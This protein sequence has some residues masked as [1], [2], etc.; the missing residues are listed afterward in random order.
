MHPV[1]REGITGGL[2]LGDLVFVMGE[3]E[4]HPTTVDIE[5][6]TEIARCHR[7]AL[8]MPTG[9]TRTPGRGPLRLAGL[10]GLRG[11]P[12]S[13]VTRVALDRGIGV[14]RGLH[15][16]EALPAQGA[17]LREGA[18]VEV[19]IATGGVGMTVVDEALHELDHFGHVTGG[20]RLVGRWQAAEHVVGP[21]EGTLIAHSHLP[22]GHALLG[23]PREDLV[24]DVGDVAHE[25]DVVARG[26]QPPPQ[27]VEG[28][29]GS[30]VAHMGWRLH[31]GPAEVDRHPAR[32]QGHEVAHRA[33]RGVVEAQGH[34]HRLVGHSPSGAGA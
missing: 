13:E 14:C 3:E 24:V 10:G 9:A 17:V 31:R 4:V 30:D 18:H 1:L 15:V 20:T 26:L 19:D 6:G 16:V 22:E 29:A 21:G 33:G 32:L 25:G 11:L 12:Q 2:G 8:E 5:C 28:Q 27:D 7:G 34:P 23:T